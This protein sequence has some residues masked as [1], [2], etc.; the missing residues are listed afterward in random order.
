MQIQPRCTRPRYARPR[1][2]CT[3]LLLSTKILPRRK[4]KQEITKEEGVG[5]SQEPKHELSPPRVGWRSSEG[6]PIGDRNYHALQK[7]PARVYTRTW[8]Q[9]VSKRD[10]CEQLSTIEL[11]ASSGLQSSYDSI[12]S[13][14]SIIDLSCPCEQPCVGIHYGV[15]C[16]IEQSSIPILC[17]DLALYTPLASSVFIYRSIIVFLSTSDTNPAGGQLCL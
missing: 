2:V 12:I 13:P 3:H 1:S 6:G 11:F 5:D 8:Y 16:R 15:R 14:D 4:E 7:L 17:T 10:H 9:P